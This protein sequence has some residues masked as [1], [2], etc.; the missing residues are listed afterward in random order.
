MI[1][2]DV[3]DWMQR[4]AMAKRLQQMNWRISWR[5]KMMKP[6]VNRPSSD[7]NNVEHAMTD[8]FCCIGCLSK[9]LLQMT[10]D[11]LHLLSE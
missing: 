3:D 4:W 2:S 11:L 10:L 7:A 9:N 6:L 5:M 8:D 1:S